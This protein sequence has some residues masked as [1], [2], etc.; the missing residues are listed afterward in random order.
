MAV[1]RLV[2]FFQNNAAVLAHPCMMSVMGATATLSIVGPTERLRKAGSVLF[3]VT[4]SPL[5][6]SAG[7][8]AL[9]GDREKS[10]L[11]ALLGAIKLGASSPS[12]RTAVL[13]VFEHMRP[14]S[15]PLKNPANEP[16]AVKAAQRPVEFTKYYQL[17][18]QLENAFKEDQTLRLSITGDLS[19]VQVFAEKILLKRIHLFNRIVHYMTKLKE[20]CILLDFEKNRSNFQLRLGA[21]LKQIEIL[22]KYAEMT[23]DKNNLSY[24]RIPLKNCDNPLLCFERINIEEWSRALEHINPSS[25]SIL[26]GHMQ[27]LQ[28]LIS[29]KK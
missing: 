1:S 29:E 14:V 13:G 11:F 19:K 9:G 8:S 25:V 26:I 6:L 10:V 12:V 22:V 16:E 17:L 21:L 20:E 3:N 4:A 23:F 2:D 15:P 27:K 18:I 5:L 24:L 7:V 28:N